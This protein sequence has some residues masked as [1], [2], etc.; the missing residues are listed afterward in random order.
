MFSV[1][2]TELQQPAGDMTLPTYND[3]TSKVARATAPHTLALGPNWGALHA[4]LGNHGGEHALGFLAAGGVRFT[5]LE[6]GAGSSGR[7]F[8]A[9][10]VIKLLVA[11]AKLK[12]GELAVDVRRPLQKVRTFLAESVETDR[13]LIVH[14][15]G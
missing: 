14:L 5:P 13:G 3:I 4:A 15:F 11:V 1:E 8:D 10:A 9:A 12:E 7:Y 6:D 2:D